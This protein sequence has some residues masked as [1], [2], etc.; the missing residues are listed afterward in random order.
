MPAADDRR[1]P[2][3]TPWDDLR[4]GGSAAVKE[5]LEPRLPESSECTI[6]IGLRGVRPICDCA[7]PGGPAGSFS[8]G[9]EKGL[10][11]ASTEKLGDR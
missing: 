11:V 9:P 3:S 7:A 1:E 10:G 8:G 5:P 6:F 4:E 2:L